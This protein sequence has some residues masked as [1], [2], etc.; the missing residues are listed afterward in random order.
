MKNKYVIIIVIL[1]ILCAICFTIWK[2]TT[3]ESDMQ[4]L[5][6]FRITVTSYLDL[7]PSEGGNN[8]NKEAYFLFSLS[9]ISGYEF[10]ENYE[11]DSIKLNDTVIDNKKIIYEDNEFR[12]Y[13]DKYKESNELEIIIK[14]KKNNQKYFK[15][16]KVSTSKVY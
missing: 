4:E 1:A 14:N 6:D 11:I 9:G 2:L 3:N 13:S 7:M 12:F 16:L 15:N 10:M 8:R 5:K